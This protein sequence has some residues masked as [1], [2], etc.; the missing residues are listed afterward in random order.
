MYRT[1]I[2]FSFLFLF[3]CASPTKSLEKGNF[4]QAYK[5]SL[6]A[7]EKGKLY[8]ENQ[9]ILIQALDGI[10]AK[11]T[12]KKDRWLN[13]DDLK[14][15][16]K[17]I[18]FNQNI[19]GKIEKALPYLDG[20]FDE[21]LERLKLEEQQTNNFLAN[22]Y[23]SFGKEKLEK[24][25]KQ[26][27]KRFAQ[28]AYSNFIQAKKFDS[29]ETDLNTLTQRS[30]KLGRV[31]Y[32]IITEAPFDIMSHWEIDRTF[33]DMGG[34]QSDFLIVYYGGVNLEEVDCQITIRFRG[35]DIDLD[36]DKNKENFKKEIV[37]GTTTI[38]NSNGEEEEVDVIEEV[39][40]SVTIQQFKK[41]ATW[42]VN[43]EVISNSKNCELGDASFEEETIST[44]QVITLDGDERAIPNEYK[45]S[46]SEELAKDDDMAEILLEVLYD[47]ISSHI[48]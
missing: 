25:E 14:S 3:Q 35:L 40:G 41:T 32:N 34:S 38:T 45:K 7:L 48:F 1:I 36:E 47:R 33:E 18:K 39:E 44:S 5:S 31:V 12:V 29:K 27:G 16:E 37:T 9:K 23:F 30:L 26:Q 8:D 4:Q 11:E 15:K 20:K 19:Q 28:D 21:N 13:A 17:S 6:A 24:A 10:I 42:N 2:I 43:V 46:K 22:E